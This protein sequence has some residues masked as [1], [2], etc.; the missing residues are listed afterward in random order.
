MSSA[1]MLKLLPLG[2]MGSSVVILNRPGANVNR[3]G[4]SVQGGSVAVLFRAAGVMLVEWDREAD[5]NCVSVSSK[6]AP[7]ESSNCPVD[8]EENSGYF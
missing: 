3:P 6:A 2:N 4:P 7:L 8:G 1:R 5:F